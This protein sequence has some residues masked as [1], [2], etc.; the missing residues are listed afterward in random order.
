[1]STQML[2]SNVLVLNKIYNPIRTI[3]VKDAFCKIFT[4]AAEIITIENGQY[5]SYNFASWAEVSEYKALFESTDEDWINTTSLKLAV[6]RV[7]RLLKYD[8]SPK[9]EL[10]LTRK[11]IYERDAYT[12]QYCGKTLSTEKLNL[13]H[14]IPRSRGGKN[15]WDNLVCSCITCNRKKKARTPK[16]AGM[17]LH[18]IPYKPKSI[19]GFKVPQTPK[20]YKDWDSFISYQYWNT[21]L[22][23]N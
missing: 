2:N 17:Y 20:R 10:R 21:E 11:N 1:M 9:L 16:E 4:E 8:K 22:K 6:P 23:E 7:I 18:I 15:T 13:D 3:T 19:P 12:C 14:V 5:T